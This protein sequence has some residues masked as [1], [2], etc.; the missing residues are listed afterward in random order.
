MQIQY[1]VFL[2]V[3]AV[4]LLFA[5]TRVVFAEESDVSV[6]HVNEEET[7]LAR[8]LAA[9]E[10][11]EPPFEYGLSLAYRND[12]LTWSTGTSSVDT[13]SELSWKE[14]NITQVNLAAKAKLLDDWFIQGVF[15]TGAVISGNNRDSDYAGNQRTQ[16]YARTESKSGGSVADLT[17]GFGRVWRVRLK[18]DEGVLRVA[19][20]MGFSFH[21]QSLTMSDGMKT[22]PFE[23][24]LSGLNNNYETLWRTAWLGI[25]LNWKVW[26]NLSVNAG[27]Q[28]HRAEYSAKANWN[29]RSD[30]AHPVSFEHSANGHGSV[31]SLG[32]CYSVN[33]N[34]LLNSTLAYQRWSTN[35]GL[36]RTYQSSGQIIDDTLNPVDWRS[37]SISFGLIYQF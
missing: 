4:T 35:A 20:A 36:D 21:T 29:L 1:S 37:N 33:N 15:L 8:K 3:C 27:M 17:L 2:T 24:A 18:D 26:Q 12:N 11:V 25:D 5:N 13:A 14:T 34:L 10:T 30:L 32:L 28:Y 22:V 31:L 19:P 7:Q 6:L 9:R 23:A 16:E